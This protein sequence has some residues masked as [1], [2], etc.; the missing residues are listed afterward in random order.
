M[1]SRARL[2]RR[3]RP[4]THFRKI[5]VSRWPGGAGLNPILSRSAASFD[6][7]QRGWESLVA[8]RILGGALV[9][10]FLGSV[11]VIELNRQGLLP[12]PFDRILTTN[13]FGALDLAFTFLLVIEVLGL[14]VALA[15]SVANSV[16]KQFELLSLILLRKAFL[17]F[18]EFGEP[19]V[20]E[21]VSTAVLHMSAYAGAAL[22]IFV[23]LG[24]YYRVQVHQRITAD[25]EEQVSFVAAKKL[26]AMLLLA[27]FLVLGVIDATRYLWE[28][29]TFDLFAAF[30]LVLIFSDVLIVLISLAYSSAYRVVFRN[31]GFAAATVLMRLALTAPPYVS[32]LLGVGSALF[33]LGLSFAYGK[34]A[35]VMKEQTGSVQ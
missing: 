7:F 2:C 12:A 14:V 19:I 18:A 6:A 30:Y 13:H 11:V 4:Y 27:S 21:E 15:D 32:G 25:E 35:P 20:W 3:A 16:G 31:S 26:V 1:Y 23:V 8:R 29:A 10:A 5:T 33:A 28:G 17:E 22:L 34:F 24:F 9:V